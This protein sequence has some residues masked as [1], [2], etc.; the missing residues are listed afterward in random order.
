MDVGNFL[1]LERALHRDRMV[2][3]AAQKQRVLL[4]DE[5]LGDGFDLRIQA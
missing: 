5:V 2:F 3:A 4:V 1:E